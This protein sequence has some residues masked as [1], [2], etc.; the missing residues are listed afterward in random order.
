MNPAN[1]LDQQTNSNENII[2]QD[3]ESNQSFNKN[4]TTELSENKVEEVGDPTVYID[5]SDDDTI[6]EGEIITS[7]IP[8][9]QIVDTIVTTTTN[10]DGSLKRT[11]KKTTRTVLTTARIRKVK[12]K[13]LSANS[14][15]SQS[16]SYAKN[17]SDMPNIIN[18]T[19]FS[20]EKTDGNSLAQATLAIIPPQTEVIYQEN[21]T[22]IGDIDPDTVAQL[23]Q[24]PDSV[25][26]QQAITKTTTKKT[27][28]ATA[29]TATFYATGSEA[30]SPNIFTSNGDVNAKNNN[31]TKLSKDFHQSFSLS[32][33]HEK[34]R[35]NLN[36]TTRQNTTTDRIDY[37]IDNPINNHEFATTITTKTVTTTHSSG[38]ATT[39]TTTTTTTMDD[40]NNN[41][42]RKQTTR[43]TNNFASKRF[44]FTL[45]KPFS[46]FS[47]DLRTAIE[48]GQGIQNSKTDIVD[49][50]QL[51]LMTMK[52]SERMFSEAKSM[53]ASNQT[54]TSDKVS[55]SRGSKANNKINIYSKNEDGTVQGY[56]SR[57][58]NLPLYQ[59]YGIIAHQIALSNKANTAKKS[60]SEIQKENDDVVNGQ[61][62]S[63]SPISASDSV[64][65]RQISDQSGTDI[66][67]VANAFAHLLDESI[68]TFL[69]EAT[70]QQIVKSGSLNLFDQPV[71]ISDLP[72]NKELSF[73]ESANERPALQENENCDISPSL[74]SF[75][76]KKD[77]EMLELKQQDQHDI[78][79]LREIQGSKSV[80]EG[81]VQKTSR[82][83][84][85]NQ[86]AFRV[87]WS[88]M[89]EVVESNCLQRLTRHEI[90]L[91]EAMFEVITSEA[92]YY[93]SLNVLVNH[94]YHAPE[95]ECEPLYSPVQG[96]Q[97]VNK[98]GKDRYSPPP[99]TNTAG[100]QDAANN[101]DQVLSE[102]STPSVSV[103]PL[104]Q[105][106]SNSTNT[107]VNN[108]N[109]ADFADVCPDGIPSSNQTTTN[110]TTRRPL[111]KPLEKHHLFSNVLLV[112]LASEMFLRDL[113]ARWESRMPIL[114]EVCDLI[115][116][117][118]GGVNF[119]PYITYLRNQTYQM[120]TLQ[121][122]CQRDSFRSALDNL[123]AHP[124]SGK[125]MINSFLALPMQRLTRLKLLVEVIRRLQD[126]VVR[127]S[128]DKS[129]EKHPF[130]VPSDR[131]RENVQ[132]A[133]RELNRLLTASE[134]EKEL[135]DRKSRLLTLSSSLEF[136]DNVKRIS[137]SDKRLIKEGELREYLSDNGRMSV[138]QKLTIRKPNT[139]Y[140]ILFND[141]LLVTKKKKNERFLVLDYCDRASIQALVQHSG[142]LFNPNTNLLKNP[143]TSI[144]A[145]PLCHIDPPNDDLK[146]VPQ[147]SRR[148]LSP[149][150]EEDVNDDKSKAKHHR[151]F[152]T[153]VDFKN[154]IDS[155]NNDNQH[156][157]NRIH[158]QIETNES[159][160]NYLSLDDNNQNVNN[161]SNIS[162]N[163]T[164]ITTTTTTK[165]TNS[166]VIGNVNTSK[167]TNLS[168]SG[169][170]LSG[171]QLRFSQEKNRH[172]KSSIFSTSQ[173]STLT[174][175]KTNII[176]LKLLGSHNGT[177][178]ELILSSS[179]NR[180]FES[181]C[182]AFSV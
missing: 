94:F 78:S 47:K 173:P 107:I 96:N 40:N 2:N 110:T 93:Q 84:V 165:A 169:S 106:I 66:N 109:N 97:T 12:V 137:I 174:N 131:E 123:H 23:K 172:I 176:Y 51:A 154:V 95:F 181:W 18:F 143:K 43:V 133:L 82:F 150:S 153:T 19:K 124:R 88:E 122:L 22:P 89:P 98:S 13:N 158:S 6:A 138:L 114:N 166:I 29:A 16:S 116:K 108:N 61:Q 1:S 57:F 35:K 144:S 24:S 90:Q 139:F 55:Q 170:S 32:S 52:E 112:C 64:N 28:S 59:G 134:T 58:A 49:T 50:E 27:V 73:S 87:A 70:N 72:Q 151:H 136:P 121:K 20:S 103:T 76:D 53:F 62:T 65:I 15:S 140:L 60:T 157:T 79:N 81:L 42:T 100:Q 7:T 119:E 17:H 56:Q 33:L 71:C 36:D 162:T 14:E 54:L 141:M 105:T 67:L 9:T 3:S 5:D 167:T 120:A 68:L 21:V 159:N 80:S 8:P 180:E 91:Q 125:N 175:C 48:D 178:T 129:L 99:S 147:K 145:E 45:K 161:L 115:V 163:H 179:D 83:G 10:P 74:T 63:L 126:A 31:N 164:D 111:L 142:D 41:G 135:M 34:F 132:L 39:T 46:L 127:D 101:N 102:P 177:C 146:V 171:Y 4:I 69:Y 25:L 75:K 155:N 113:E 44:F 128:K 149:G 85:G 77:E 11:T 117:H 160:R 92:S 37:D 148:L 168:R 104:G 38:S 86:G 118:A 156:Q 30:M 182:K 130:R 26:P 152:R